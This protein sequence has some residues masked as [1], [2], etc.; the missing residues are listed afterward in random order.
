[1]YNYGHGRP[2]KFFQGGQR[3]YF[4]YRFQIADDAI[5]MDVH[6][7]IYTFYTTKKMPRVVARVTKIARL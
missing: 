6:K 2:Q 4:A 3:R 5:E 7:R 1:M